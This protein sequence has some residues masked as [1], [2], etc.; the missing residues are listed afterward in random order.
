MR[1]ELNKLEL[2]YGFV[3]SKAESNVWYL[4]VFNDSNCDMKIVIR[5]LRG[6]KSVRISVAETE[7]EE[8]ALITDTIDLI[9]TDN[10]KKLK[11]LILIL[12]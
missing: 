6:D 11:Q 4:N 8:S 3:Q 7:T 2:V 5:L 10:I 12:I 1:E 9:E